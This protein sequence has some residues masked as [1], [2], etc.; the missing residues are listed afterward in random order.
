MTL[1]SIDK[2]YPAGTDVP[3]IIDNDLRNL[4]A[5]LQERLDR[6]HDFTLTGNLINVGVNG[7]DGDVG[8]HR[9]V[10][11]VIAQATPTP[12]AGQAILYTKTVSGK[13]ELHWCDTDGDEKQ[14]TALD[15]NGL[16]YIYNTMNDIAYALEDIVTGGADGILTVTN[17]GLTVGYGS[18]RPF[19]YIPDDGIYENMIKDGEVTFAKLT[20]T[21]SAIAKV[22]I[23]TYTGNGST[24]GPAV[25]GVGFQ[26][27]AVLIVHA[28]NDS[29]ITGFRSQ[30][31]GSPV[32]GPLHG[33]AG[34]GTTSGFSTGIQWDADGFTIKTSNSLVNASGVVYT[35]KVEKAL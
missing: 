19:L 7:L 26:P 22:K 21:S 15:T 18:S 11:F 23:G 33:S 27:D 25:T 2:S 16:P 28:T 10:T 5:G 12:V 31:S 30:G 34:T 3:T 24:S 20:L 6:D 29:V 9:Q 35:Y 17:T 4:K 8:K 14:L 32:V 13:P 1:T